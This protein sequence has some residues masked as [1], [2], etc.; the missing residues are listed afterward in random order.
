[1][2][3][4]YPRHLKLVLAGDDGKQID[5]GRLS[6]QFEVVR[7]SLG[8]LVRAK[9]RVYNLAPDTIAKVQK[10]FTRMRLD[11]GHAQRFGTIFEGDIQ[12]AFT[13]RDGADRMTDIFAVSGAS[14][15]RDATVQLSFPAGESLKNV[16]LQVAETFASV[17][18]GPGIDSIQLPDTA[19]VGS[20]TITGQT[21]IEMD[22]LSK[23]YDFRWAIDNNRVRVYGKKLLRGGE[24]IKIG[25]TTGLIASPTA[26]SAGIEF[27]SLLD[28][29]IQPWQLVEISTFGSSAGLPDEVLQFQDSSL[30]I[31]GLTGGRFDIV[32]VVHVGESRGQP[33]YSTAFAFPQ[34]QL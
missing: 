3:N 18:D 10:K 34:G 22:R 12:H 6:C 33:W 24:A 9:V 7:D 23:S 2:P 30:P 21:S 32:S 26:S 5:L 15:L 8:G 17:K 4:L 13:T 27:T 11:A 31:K 28:P 25:P 16:V 1:M 20:L 29:R 19:L 14:A